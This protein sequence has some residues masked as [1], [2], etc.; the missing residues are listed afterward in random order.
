MARF[1]KEVM[2]RHLHGCKDRI[3]TSRGFK[4]GDGWV[5]VAGKEIE[6]IYDF[7]RFAE[8]RNL[9]DDIEAGIAT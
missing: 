1:S 7:G 2:L 5:A 9:I 4:D 8:L 3:A 6:V